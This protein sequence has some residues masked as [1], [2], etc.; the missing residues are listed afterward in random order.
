MPLGKWLINKLI[1]E[2]KEIKTIVAIYPGR[3]QPMGKHHAETFKWLSKKFDNAYVA[4]SGKVDLPKSPFN[5][6]EKKK[7][8]NSYGISKIVQVKNPYKAEEIL[9][10]Y[11][12]E[13]T[14]AV[15]MVGQ[16]DASRLQGKFFRPWKGKA[17]VSYKDG[18]Y[19]LIAPHISLNIPGYGEMSGTTIRTAL[20]DKS[21]GIKEKKKLFKGIFGHTKN[22]DLII[23]KLESLQESFMKKFIIKSDF[24]KMINEETSTVGSGKGMVD[25]GP[26]T[27]FSSFKGYSSKG[28]F[29]AKQIGWTVVDYILSGAKEV[30][31]K[32]DRS[33]DPVTYFPAGVA[34]EASPLNQTDLRGT[35]AYKAYAKRIS[36]IALQLGYKFLDF[37]GAE[38]SKESS[39]G[40]PNKSAKTPTNLEE[41]LLDP[42]MWKSIMETITLPVEIGDTVYMGKFKNKKVVVKTISWN[43]K[44]DLLINGKS[45]MRMRIPPKPN[46]FDEANL[47]ESVRGRYKN[48]QVPNAL[49]SLEDEKIQGDTIQWKMRLKNPKRFPV[50]KQALS[51]KHNPQLEHEVKIQY[52]KN[53]GELV[54]TF[55]EDDEQ[56]VHSSLVHSG[57]FSITESLLTEGGAY[58]HMAH[59][60]DDRGL[61]FGDFKN[62]IELSLQGQLDLESGATEKTDG[63]NL[64][65]TWSDGKLKA[66]RNTGD[67]KRG[68]MDSKAV[69][70]KFKGRGNIEKAFNF[71]MNDL[72]KAIG[73]LNDKQK[74]KIFDDGNNWVNMEIM[75]PA[76]P[77]VIVYDAPHLQF[78]NVLRYKDGKAIGAVSDGARILAG[79]IQQV[80]ANVQKNFSVIG[81]QILKVNPHQDYGAKRSYFNSKLDKLKSKFGLSD[82]AT[83]A[84]YHQAWWEDYVDKN[85]P[86]I[87]NAIK[88]GLV[89]R[90]AFND[91]SYRLNGKTIPDKELLDKIKS[92]DKV[93]V[94]Q[95]VKK[96]ML[97]FEN[98]FFELGA[99]VLKNA[100][101]FLAAN[102]D[103]SVQ[104]VRKQVAKA[105]RDVRK[106]GDLK[107]L[108]KVKEQLAKIQAIGGFEKI[109]PSEGLVFIY[110]GNTYKLTGI[111]APVNQIT[112]L[113]TF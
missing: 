84:E 53:T 80:N 113:M 3:F 90:W 27:M 44:G 106:G 2:D 82:S 76:S 19:T 96:N 15:F 61:T 9:K 11:D 42:G 31:I 6:N 1:S 4:T 89:K 102:P 98:L 8:I 78:H 71:A 70:S 55:H 17:E 20:G 30:K 57:F 64:F 16:K 85:F 24:K 94:E 48:L 14:A 97:P 88:M 112:G 58:G 74:A 108:N 86:G 111:F 33:I 81:P 83:F 60:F 105:I 67:V 95:Q 59:P 109:V 47:N 92:L 18:A 50:L 77:N 75:Y 51:K 40:E 41:K 62:I 68:G 91:K 100:E 25:D 28:D 12:P 93:K 13:T 32:P 5:F 56:L 37:M 63:Q 22:Y 99:E 46:I 26:V 101:G 10:K 87:E 72:S 45:A 73:S 107:K 7:I 29:Y 103:K 36:Q 52:N 104:A 49:L 66:A 23:K 38:E 34:G 43:E 54:L 65:I 69:A 110:K 21:L 79:M 35:P 39:K